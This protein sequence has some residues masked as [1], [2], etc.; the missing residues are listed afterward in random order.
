MKRFIPFSEKV[1]D[2]I[3]ITETIVHSL[4]Y[5]DAAAVMAIKNEDTD[6]LLDIFKQSLKASDRLTSIALHQQD[7]EETDERIDTTDGPGFGFELAKSLGDSQEN[8]E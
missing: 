4:T 5:L 6:L 7:R 8:D 3:D 2:E 1:A